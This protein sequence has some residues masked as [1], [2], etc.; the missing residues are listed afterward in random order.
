MTDHTTIAP[1]AGERYIRIGDVQA[2]IAKWRGKPR[3]QVPFEIRALAWMFDQYCRKVHEAD[4]LLTETFRLS[5]LCHEYQQLAAD[6]V[7]HAVDCG[8]FLRRIGQQRAQK[9]KEIPQP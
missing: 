2:M 9:W 3:S 5:A 1:P 6:T 4:A 7:I 8:D